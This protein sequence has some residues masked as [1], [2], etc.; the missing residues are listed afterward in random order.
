M[1]ESSTKFDE[2]AKHVE[3]TPEILECY[4][5]LGDGSHIL[6]IIVKDTASLEK[7]LSTIQSWPGV[8]RTVTSFVLSTIKETTKISI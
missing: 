4:S 1:M 3:E 2:L 7:L 5:V 6:K 8:V